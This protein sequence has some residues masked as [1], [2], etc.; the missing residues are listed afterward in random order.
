[1]MILLRLLAAHFVGD[2]LL[3]PDALCQRKLSAGREGFLAI[4]FH[5]AIQAALAYLFV[6]DWSCWVIPPVIFLTH[7]LIDLWKTHFGRDS[8]MAFVVDQLLHILVIMLLWAF[9]TGS[10]FS[11]F[12]EAFSS[13]LV[14]RKFWIIAVAYIIILRPTSVFIRLFVAKWTPD[15]NKID[16]SLPNAGMWI[17]YL[18]RILIVTFVVTSNIEAVG[19]L[20]A[21]KSIFRFGELNKAAEI[22][23]TEY[24]LIGTF[25]SFT[26][27]LLVGFGV[28][29]LL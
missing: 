25:A 14:C 3:Q 5:S 15:N 23:T 26:I 10:N 29:Y 27:A 11:A 13:I 12:E 22:K 18:E 9:L 1:M 7:C 24:V 4:L 2:F 17:G 20:L 8:T 28:N 6:A 16:N 19:F 21:A